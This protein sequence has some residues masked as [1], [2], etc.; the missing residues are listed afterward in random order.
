MLLVDSREYIHSNCYQ[1]QLKATLEL[2]YDVRMVSLRDIRWLP[3]TNGGRYDLVLSVL[4]LRT[5]DMHLE[6]IASYLAGRRLYIYEQDPWQ[7]FMDSSP[8]R[9]AYQRIAARLDVAAFLLT[10]SWWRSYVT[11]LGLPAKFVR[12]GMLPVYC[13]PGPDWDAREIRLGFQGTLHPHRKDFYA[14]VELKGLRTEV[15]PPTAYDDYLKNLHRMRFFIHTEDAPWTVDGRAIPRNALWIK[16]TEVAARGTFAI[17]DHEEESAAYGIAELP[18][19]RTFKNLEEIPDIVAGIESLSPSV[20]RDMM[21]SSAET[22]R[23]R[24]DW[25][26]VVRALE[27]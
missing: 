21:V 26:T 19:V 3:W 14:A 25:M 23:R 17:R 13:D 2:H 24:D 18:T 1:K 4:K 7:A 20:R 8:Y 12:M 27:P 15:L 10:S 22:M 11:E 6:R 9:G 5:L 16:E